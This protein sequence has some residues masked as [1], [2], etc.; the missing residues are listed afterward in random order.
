MLVSDEVITRMIFLV[1]TYDKVVSNDRIF[2]E[3]YLDSEFEAAAPFYDLDVEEN[4]AGS[5]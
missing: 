3:G 2:F 4:V 5:T 1:Q